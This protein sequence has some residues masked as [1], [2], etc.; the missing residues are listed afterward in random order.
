MKKSTTFF[1]IIMFAFSFTNCC[2]FSQIAVYYPLD[3]AFNTIEY[4]IQKLRP[5]SIKQKTYLLKKR[6]FPPFLTMSSLF[7]NYPILFPQMIEFG[8]MTLLPFPG[9]QYA[10][11]ILS[12]QMTLNGSVPEQLSMSFMCSP[13]GIVYIFMITVVGLVKYR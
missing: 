12:Q 8:S 4:D 11:F 2:K 1:I 3:S 13:V 10:N 9:A 6:V 5:Q 7:F